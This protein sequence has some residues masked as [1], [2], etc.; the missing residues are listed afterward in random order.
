MAWTARVT[1]KQFVDGVVK[2]SLEFTD[3]VKTVS[4]TYVSSAPSE[5][6]IADTVRDRINA[7]KVGSAFDIPIGSIIPSDPIP[8]PDDFGLFRSR[9][10]LLVL[11]KVLIDLGLILPTNPEVVALGDWVK[12]NFD[13]YFGRM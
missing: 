1:D 4:E 3:G 2:V 6:W 12:S 8:T 9:M 11:V 13:T 5:T 7:L 10:Q